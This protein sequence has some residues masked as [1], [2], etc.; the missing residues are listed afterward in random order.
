MFLCCLSEGFTAEGTR[1]FNVFHDQQSFCGVQAPALRPAVRQAGAPA[2]R[3]PLSCSTVHQLL[4][5]L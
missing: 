1:V 2:D 4:P 3:L 5:W